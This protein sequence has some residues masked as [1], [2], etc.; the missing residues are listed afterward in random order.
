MLVVRFGLAL[1]FATLSYHLVE[2][3]EARL[4]WGARRL[5]LSAA[6]VMGLV[7]A[8]ALGVRHGADTLA[9][10]GREDPEPRPEHF[11]VVML[12]DSTAN[13]LGWA[14]RGLREPDS[15]VHLLGVDGC[16]ML[17]DSC[18]ASRWQT[19]G[20]SL[21]AE[22]NVVVLG[23]AFMYG[24]H[25]DE[26]W[27]EP[28]YPKL[29]EVFETKLRA[30]LTELAHTAPHRVWLATVPY[31]L[32]PWRK[33]ASNRAKVDCVNASLRATAASVPGVQ[34]LELA[35]RLCPRGHCQES[36]STGEIRPD[37]VHYSVAG[38]NELSDWIMAQVRR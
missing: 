33:G 8:L 3:P 13:S 28:C 30:R 14:L 26:A 21:G 32:G 20:S 11:Q 17:L 5:L 34:V 37:G 23:G 27:R 15:T 19:Y 36:T 1:A 2:R 10:D 16:N 29:S 12:G 9:Q 24:M 35:E 25:L 22:A 7:A 6:G 18:R 4:R 38:A 31:P